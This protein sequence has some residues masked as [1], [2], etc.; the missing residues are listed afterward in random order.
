MRT[1]G[2]RPAAA[3]AF[4]LAV[5]SHTASDDCAAVMTIRIDSL[6]RYPVKGLSAE[7]IASVT[8]AAG[9]PFPHDRRF[10]LAHGSSRNAGADEGGWVR[11]AL[12]LQLMSNEKLATLATR[13]DPGTG[14][15]TIRRN[16]R[17]VA[18]GTITEPAGK[19]VIEQFFAAYMGDRLLGGPRLIEAGSQALTDTR[20]PWI[21]IVNLASVRDLGRVVGRTVDP[22]RFRAN[23]LVDGVP[24]W[25]ERAW[26]DRRLACGTAV[27][28]VE[29]PT[30]R[31][32]ATNV[33]P[34]TGAR[35]MRLPHAMHHAY[36]HQ[37][38]GVYARVVEGGLFERGAELSVID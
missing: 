8:L 22:M 13:F 21:S 29:A 4:P 5:D 3:A 2:R 34:A 17:Q 28:H 26:T 20:E 10:A 35:D 6:Y 36:G 16:G 1:L 23:M 27:L 32:A 33:D 30:D 25:A 37:T 38:C 7:P 11:K 12:L 19:A 31:C 9:Q 15:L 24:A 18:R 14:Q